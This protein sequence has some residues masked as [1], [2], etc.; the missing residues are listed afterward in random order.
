MQKAHSHVSRISVYDI[1]NK[2]LEINKSADHIASG[3]WTGLNKEI[4]TKDFLGS[5]I[6]RSIY[7]WLSTNNQESFLLNLVIWPLMKW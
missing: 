4:L 5:K 3:V 7:E 1:E 2:N 6:E